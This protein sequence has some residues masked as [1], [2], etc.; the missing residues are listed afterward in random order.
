MSTQENQSKDASQDNRRITP[1]STPPQPYYDGDTSPPDEEKYPEGMSPKEIYLGIVD[2]YFDKGYR[3]RKV[4]GV[5]TVMHQGYEVEGD[6]SACWV[7]CGNYRKRD[8]EPIIYIC[9]SSYFPRAL[10]AK[11]VGVKGIMKNKCGFKNCINPK[12]LLFTPFKQYM[13]FL[14][15]K[16]GPQPRDEFGRFL[17]PTDL[18]TQ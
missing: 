4:W 3:A 6:P 9:H 2:P 14:G 7:W 11:K 16:R 5:Y 12:H 10:M 8:S 1:F 18:P 15:Q 13:A 17:P